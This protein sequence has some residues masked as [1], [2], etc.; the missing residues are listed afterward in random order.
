MVPSI[1]ST[2][3][4]G[5][6]PLTISF[7]S[8]RSPF[9]SL[10]RPAVSMITRFFEPSN[11]FLPPFAIFTESFSFSSLYT[12]TPEDAT[13]VLSWATAPGRKVSAATTPTLKPRLEYRRAS[14]AVVVV[15]PDPWTP[16]MT[17]TFVFSFPSC[18]PPSPPSRRASSS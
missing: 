3:A 13:R 6:T 9:S 11:A 12:S 17:I 2:V 14:L 4:S 1:T 5:F 8:W 18:I 7:I 10:W 16:S 15:F